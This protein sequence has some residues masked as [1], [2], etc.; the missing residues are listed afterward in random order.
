MLLSGSPY[1]WETVLPS[2]TVI[3]SAM[4]TLGNTRVQ[5]LTSE[6]PELCRR[7]G[8]LTSWSWNVFIP[9]TLAYISACHMNIVSWTL[10][11]SNVKRLRSSRLQASVF[12]VTLAYW[13]LFYKMDMLIKFNVCVVDN[14]GIVNIIISSYHRWICKFK[15]IDL[16]DSQRQD[17]FTRKINNKHDR[18]P[19][20]M[21]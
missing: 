15:K 4:V 19:T 9:G 10:F 12:I 13:L 8:V 20:D 14:S 1:S 2:T 18:Q 16:H 5:L 11:F 3:K 6:T 7:K 21:G 17:T